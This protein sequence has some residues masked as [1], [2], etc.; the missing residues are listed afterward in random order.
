MKSNSASRRIED[1]GAL[2]DWLA[3]RDEANATVAIWKSNLQVNVTGLLDLK[4]EP[5]LCAFLKRG[6]HCQLLA[7]KLVQEAK[8]FH[9]LDKSIERIDHAPGITLHEHAEA[10][11]AGADALLID[12]RSLKSAW[13]DLQ[14]IR[15]LLKTP[16]IHDRQ[17]LLDAAATAKAGLQRFSTR[18][19]QSAI[20]QAAERPKRPVVAFPHRGARNHLNP[21]GATLSMMSLAGALPRNGIEPLLV[22]FKDALS[23]SEHTGL[24]RETT[25]IWA[26]FATAHGI[27]IVTLDVPYLGK[28][29]PKD[30]A[31]AEHVGHFAHAWAR[32]VR[33]FGIDIIHTN[34]A[35][36][37]G[38][39]AIAC[40]NVEVRHVWHERGLFR[41]RTAMP[42]LERRSNKVLTISRFVKAQAPAS[43]RHRVE[44]VPNPV[45]TMTPL[46]HGASRAVLREMLGVEPAT[47]VVGMIANN[48]PRK[49]WDI[50]LAAAL[51]IIKERL[52]RGE[53]APVFVAFGG[54]AELV[55]DYLREWD[56][57]DRHARHIVA[58]GYCQEMQE[59][60][61]GLD[62]LVQT[63]EEEPLGRVVI[64]AAQ[65]GVGVLAADAGGH[66]ELLESNPELLFE[67]GCAKA[68]VTIVERYLQYPECYLDAKRKLQAQ[69]S[70]RYS[71][72][73]HVEQVL[74]AYA[75]IGV[76][77][78]EAALR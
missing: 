63:A 34:D 71:V 24:Y 46:E 6:I 9:G 50:F 55:A 19:S 72:A 37:H 77:P 67:A 69:L 22:V 16:V 26:E 41:H 30:L 32:L 28:D 57:P 31:Q 11:L 29:M 20:S 4:T 15:K 64:E 5:G 60:L 12:S 66:R 8:R 70:C 14:T 7:P 17:K 58:W 47:S 18:A 62:L 59:R 68:V 38:T 44:V 1:Y 52:E 48:N 33:D 2:A 42:F 40:E 56:V 27:N 78:G 61:A 74:K 51:E 43:L 21:S 25:G 36:T 53:P 65:L 45:E 49:R 54:G 75:S 13:P 10:T 39:I 23:G 3:S 35:A 76:E 73:A